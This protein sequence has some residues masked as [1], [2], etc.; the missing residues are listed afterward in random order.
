[1]SASEFLFCTSFFHRGGRESFCSNRGENHCFPKINLLMLSGQGNKMKYV[2]RLGCKIRWTY[3][4]LSIAVCAFSSQTIS[5]WYL[6]RS[7]SGGTSAV[8]KGKTQAK[9]SCKAKSW[10][11][12]D[13]KV[14][15][16]SFWRMWPFF[17]G[18]F[19]HQM[20]TDGRMLTIDNITI[21]N[22]VSAVLHTVD[23]HFACH[24]CWLSN[25][26]PSYTLQHRP[27]IHMET[28][29]GQCTLP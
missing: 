11:S 29:T 9:I 7:F 17:N 24:L 26:I 15:D 8:C 23:W 19:T 22:Q 2:N 12:G 20:T 4:D 6:S 18:G 5:W 21:Y 16:P 1:M 3:L 25:S 10:W 13:A 14:S 28:F 27:S